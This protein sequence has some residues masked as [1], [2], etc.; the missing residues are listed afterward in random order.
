MDAT[1]LLPTEKPTASRGDTMDRGAL[2]VVTQSDATGK[3]RGGQRGN[4]NSV[5]NG[6]RVM[7]LVSGELPAALSRVKRNGRR[8]KQALE[9]ECVARHKGVDLVQA[10]HIDAAATHELRAMIL[11]WVLINKWDTLTAKEIVAITTNIAL[12]KDAR[13]KALAE[14]D[15]AVDP[16]DWVK[17]FYAERTDTP[18]PGGGAS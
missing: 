5:R 4:I 9:A 15:L 3:R 11:R 7:R 13:N 6:S 16:D 12:A 17:T 10:H 2:A 8:Y 1:D 14:L 18:E